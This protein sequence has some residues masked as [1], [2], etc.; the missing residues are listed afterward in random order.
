MNDQLD[1]RIAAYIGP[2]MF[3][4]AADA[5]KQLGTS[6]LVMIISDG[7]MTVLRRVDV[8]AR[9]GTE[10]IRSTLSVPAGEASI[11]SG[12]PDESF[13]LFLIDG[14]EAIAAPVN[15]SLV[16]PAGNA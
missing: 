7:Q 1:P 15:A 14:E 2:E 3:Q 16:P 12:A 6:D 13:W 9:E 5:R 11:R 10:A 8:L 4:N